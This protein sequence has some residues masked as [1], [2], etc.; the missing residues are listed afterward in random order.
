MRFAN[1]SFSFLILFTGE[2]FCQNPTLAEPWTIFGRK[3]LEIELPNDRAT[4]RIDK[5]NQKLAKIVPRL[6]PDQNWT[7]DIRTTRYR[8]SAQVKS[9][10]IRLEGYN[11]IFVTEADAKAQGFGSVTEL[12]NT[13]AESLSNIFSDRNL[14][15]LLIVGMG[16]PSEINYR[17]VV[18]YLK[19]N[20][21]NDKGLFRTSGQYSVGGVVYWEVPA[22]NK[23]YQITGNYK[24][25][26][27]NSP[28]KEVFLLNRNQKFLVYSQERS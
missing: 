5:F 20:I 14:R 26:E 23:A 9:A 11:L 8:K 3:A 28:P 12:A 13:W 16:M 4:Q 24:S 18:Y 17:G 22:D 2:I 10:L 7:V 15:K 1:I 6:N 27:T 25:L 19:P 21:A